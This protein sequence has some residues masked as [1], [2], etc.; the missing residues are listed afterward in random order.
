MKQNAWI[1]RFGEI[2]LKSRVVRRQFTRALKENMKSQ[3]IAADINLNQDRI[4]TMD[5]VT[6]D[7]SKEEVEQLLSHVLGI[8]AIDPVELISE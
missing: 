8:V 7:S 2:G 1:L 4:E 5:V 3:A 6:S